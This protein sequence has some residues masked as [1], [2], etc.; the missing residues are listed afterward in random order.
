MKVLLKKG[1]TTSQQTG[2]GKDGACGSEGVRVDSNG[3]AGPWGSSPWLLGWLYTLRSPWVTASLPWEVLHAR[4]G[5]RTKFQSNRQMWCDFNDCVIEWCL[6]RQTQTFSTWILA[7]A[8][9]N[10]NARYHV[11]QIIYNLYEFLYVAKTWS[12][13]SYCIFL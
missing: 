11:L 5:E 13:C 3:C 6:W 12:F 10:E 7:G 4:K 8:I 1:I 2:E 9:R